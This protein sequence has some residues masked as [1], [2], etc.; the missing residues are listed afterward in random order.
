MRREAKVKVS[1]FV[2]GGHR[3]DEVKGRVDVRQST[4]GGDFVTQVDHD[5]LFVP[6]RRLLR[7][8]QREHLVI[9]FE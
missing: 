2:A 7:A 4:S 1:K 3:V 6:H 8:E 5:G 9:A